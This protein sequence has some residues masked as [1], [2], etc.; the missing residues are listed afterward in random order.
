MYSIKLYDHVPKPDVAESN[1]I[2]AAHYYPSW[3]KG[4]NGLIKEFED[5]HDYPDRTPLMGYY[6]DKDPEVASKPFWRF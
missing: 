1:R 2:V 3:T 5:L 4:E 6:E